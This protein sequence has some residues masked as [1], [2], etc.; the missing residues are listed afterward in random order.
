MFLSMSILQKTFFLNDKKV[1]LLYA[2][3]QAYT[4]KPDAQQKTHP[5]MVVHADS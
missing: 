3:Y 1:K 4:Q 2:E 5:T